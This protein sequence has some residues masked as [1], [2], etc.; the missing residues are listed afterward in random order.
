MGN[1]KTYE[2]T[3]WGAM[4]TPANKKLIAS[5]AEFQNLMKD[6]LKTYVYNIVAS[7]GMNG[8]TSST[9]VVYVRT[10]WQNA[11]IGTAAA[12]GVVTAGLA[13]VYVAKSVRRK[14]AEDAT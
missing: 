10:W 1:A 8:V 7:N 9:Q 6:V 12:L 3:K 4:T 5:D 2:T 11:L 13:A 14:K